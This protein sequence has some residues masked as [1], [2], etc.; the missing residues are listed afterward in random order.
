MTWLLATAAEALFVFNTLHASLK[1][2]KTAGGKPQLESALESALVSW[3]LF[4]VLRLWESLL[5]PWV[6]VLP[7]YY[8]GK[9]LLVLAVGVPALRIHVLIFEL[10]VTAVDA[11]AGERRLSLPLTAFELFGMLP[12]L[13]LDLLFPSAEDWEEES[14]APAATLPSTPR[15][16]LPP[17]E[18]PEIVPEIAPSSPERK[19]SFEDSV[20]AQRK[21]SSMRLSRLAKELRWSAQEHQGD[22]KVLA[23]SPEE[24]FAASVVRSVRSIIVGDTSTRLRD[25]VL[26]PDLRSPSLSSVIRSKRRFSALGLTQPPVSP[27][28]SR[29]R[30]RPEPKTSI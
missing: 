21:E 9:G 13:L 5:E 28:Q 11:L 24:R 10:M 15:R 2:L 18:L 22:T 6:A 19:L 17:L 7:L 4:G 20:E 26:C 27:S 12:V 3:T 25:S 16:T 30:R 29:S 8:Y 1:A 23:V 14:V